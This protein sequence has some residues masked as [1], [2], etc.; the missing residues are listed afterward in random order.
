[1]AWPKTHRKRLSYILVAPILVPLWLTLPDTR[2]PRGKKFFPITFIGS[3]GWIAAY[4][5]LMVWWA[6]VIGDTAKIPP[7]VNF[8][9]NISTKK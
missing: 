5:Y 6:N 9:N 2:T 1:M 7:E 4:S 8:I 3:I